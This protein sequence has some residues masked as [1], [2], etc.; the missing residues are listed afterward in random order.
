MHRY[1]HSPQS[2]LML[3]KD[4]MHCTAKHCITSRL[5]IL[6]THAFIPLHLHHHPLREGGHHMPPSSLCINQSERAE[7]LYRGGMHKVCHQALN[8]I[9]LLMPLYR[10]GM[11]KVCHQ[12]LKQGKAG[13]AVAWCR[14]V[15][16][17]K[18]GKSRQ[19]KA[20]KKRR[21]PTSLCPPP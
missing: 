17:G 9:D 7:L 1:T 14:I 3:R 6:S 2:F 10:G 16:C 20:S 15:R 11:H 13:R 12:A 4:T 18:A 21:E 8:D 19:G 5:M